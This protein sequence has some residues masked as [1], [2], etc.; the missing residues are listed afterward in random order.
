VKIGP[1]FQQ[2]EAETLLHCL[3]SLLGFFPRRI[4]VLGFSAFLS[5]LEVPHLPLSTGWGSFYVFRPYLPLGRHFM[6]DKEEVITHT[7]LNRKFVMPPQT[8][9]FFSKKPPIL[10]FFRL[11][12][13]DT[14]C[15]P[16]SNQV[17]LKILS[18]SVATRQRALSTS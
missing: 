17:P 11:L 15:R 16:F 5:S 13:G 14:L 12:E 8:Q 10:Y 3:Q 18:K 2:K 7:G 6:S 9:L 1:G 4:G